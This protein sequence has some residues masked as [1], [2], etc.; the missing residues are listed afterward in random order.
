MD[1]A[2]WLLVIIIIGNLFLENSSI[3]GHIIVL[4]LFSVASIVLPIWLFCTD[5]SY[6]AYERRQREKEQKRKEKEEQRR[7]EQEQKQKEKDNKNK[8]GG[9][10]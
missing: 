1:I 4:I 9:D 10:K 2:I 5:H 6:G 8:K 3:I 7:K